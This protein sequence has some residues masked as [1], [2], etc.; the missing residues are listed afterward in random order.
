MSIHPLM[1]TSL[2]GNDNLKQLK[3]CQNRPGVL[4]MKMFKWKFSH[5]FNTLIKIG[6]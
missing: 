6:N 4:L 1:S 5:V 2:D 3:G